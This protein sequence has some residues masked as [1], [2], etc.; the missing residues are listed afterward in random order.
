MSSSESSGRSN[1]QFRQ[2]R[3]YFEKPYVITPMFKALTPERTAS[4]VAELVA[5]CKFSKEDLI[6]DHGCGQGRHCFGLRGI[7]YRVAGLDYSRT[8]LKMAA[9]VARR[10]DSDVPYIRGD[11]RYLPLKDSIF[12]WVLSLFGSFGYLSET[13]NVEVLKEIRRVLKPRGKLLLEIW[14]KE[15]ALKN[16]GE[17]IHR[18][19]ESGEHFL[20]RCRFSHDTRRMTVRRFFTTG[21]KKEE[22]SI[23]YRIYTSPEISD[24]LT[25]LGFE[26]CDIRG[27]FSSRELMPESRDL[28]VIC[29]K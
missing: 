7:G 29:E 21:D 2:H 8:L 25:S 3:S 22:Y 18:N 20:Q 1:E 9:T 6:L 23:S 19:L 5:L 11:M 26:I 17:E 28:V 10:V 4:E 27:S 15:F 14:N 12:T 24:I 16:D 13:D